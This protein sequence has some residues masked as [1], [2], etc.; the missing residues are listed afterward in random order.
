[1]PTRV[2]PTMYSDTPIFQALLEGRRGRWPGIPMEELP[3]VPVFPIAQPQPNAPDDVP[4]MSRVQPIHA[5]PGRPVT[6]YTPAA[7]DP[8]ETAPML[9]PHLGQG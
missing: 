3:P 2:D 9:I 7:Y 4:V 6:P 1:M 8:E 5:T